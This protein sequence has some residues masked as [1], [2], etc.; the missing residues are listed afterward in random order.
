VWLW[1]VV[2]AGR[3]RVVAL[4]LG[5]EVHDARGVDVAGESAS[6]VAEAA[7]AGGLDLGAA[8]LTRRRLRAARLAVGRARVHCGLVH[9][10]ELDGA[11]RGR[12][13]GHDQ[14]RYQRRRVAR[15]PP[16][17]HP[18]R[19]NSRARTDRHD[20]RYDRKHLASLCCVVVV[21][22]ADQSRTTATETATAG[23]I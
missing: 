21:T 9:A 7:P 19:S 8:E 1:L 6:V 3:R 23:L 13:H 18:D 14:H 20:L 10:A 11:G 12:R 2:V 17:G 22:S 16:P 4:A 15:L 5:G